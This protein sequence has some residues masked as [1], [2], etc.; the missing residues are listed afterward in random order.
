LGNT[1]VKFGGDIILAVNGEPLQDQAQLSNILLL[2]KPGSIVTLTVLR[3]GRQIQVPI[4]LGTES[5]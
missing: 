3:N 2:Q 5:V 1:P 4:K